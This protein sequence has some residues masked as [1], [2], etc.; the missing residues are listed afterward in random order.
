[1]FRAIQDV[2]SDP[3]K[4]KDIIAYV[5]YLQNN[6]NKIAIVYMYRSDIHNIS[7]LPDGE[8]QRI[9]KVLSIDYNKFQVIGE[10]TIT[11]QEIFDGDILEVGPLNDF[12][13]NLPFNERKFTKFRNLASFQDCESK[14]C[15]AS[16]NKCDEKKFFYQDN[17]E[18]FST[19]KQ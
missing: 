15:I 3:A 2:K 17:K 18:N 1:M 16:Y 12:Y 8:K 7:T 10:S 4:G 9:K 14:E 13:R 11:K 19:R 5:L 6:S